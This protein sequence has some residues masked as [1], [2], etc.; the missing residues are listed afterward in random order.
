[1]GAAHAA[2]R[3]QSFLYGTGMESSVPEII[4]SQESLNLL[5]RQAICS[6]NH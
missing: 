6:K 1:M 4:L 3:V 5:C 2:R